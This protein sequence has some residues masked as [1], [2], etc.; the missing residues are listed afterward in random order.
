[1]KIKY[2]NNTVD[3][4]GLEE[5][6]EHLIAVYDNVVVYHHDHSDEYLD[7]TDSLSAH[8]QIAKLLKCKIDDLE[9]EEYSTVPNLDAKVI[10]TY[11]KK[12]T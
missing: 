4:D 12:H 3:S 10:I 2:I 8:K 9:F 6:G 5:F 11:L 1:M 7:I